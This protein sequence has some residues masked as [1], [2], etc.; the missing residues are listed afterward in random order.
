MS[1]HQK[2]IWEL[3]R[4]VAMLLA[5]YALSA[6][7]HRPQ[8]NCGAQI[9]NLDAISEAK[10][11]LLG[12]IHGTQEIPRFAGDI[13]CSVVRGGQP[14]I[15]AL[16]IPRNEQQRI[17]AYVESSGDTVARL[18]LVDSDFWRKTLDG[19]ATVAI[20]DLIEQVRSL[21]SAGA[22]ASI[23]AMDN[24][25][26]DANLPACLPLRSSFSAAPIA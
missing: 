16:E 8:V 24:G 15:V 20:A 3:P 10:V 9:M 19:R 18:A 23:V 13:A 6:C 21:K 22:I 2:Q 17:D 1:L 4:I 12:E 5:L 14:I 11:V 25:W 26:G 7:V